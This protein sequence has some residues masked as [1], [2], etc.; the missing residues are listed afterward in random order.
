MVP[1]V[2]A[3][4]KDRKS[5]HVNKH[6]RALN[7]DFSNLPVSLLLSTYRDSRL[8]RQPISTGIIPERELNP[9]SKV[10][11]PARKPISDGK[12]PSAVE[13]KEDKALVHARQQQ[14]YDKLTR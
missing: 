14:F 1:K 6:I 3:T 12:V 2:F 9:M 5:M 11:R 10:V 8:V 7:L 4:P 13:T